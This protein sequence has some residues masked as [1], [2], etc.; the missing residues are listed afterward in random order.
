M[1]RKRMQY[2]IAVLAVSAAAV[3]AKTMSVQVREGVLRS[4]PS[5]LGSPVAALAYGDRV[6]ALEER[7][8]WMRV[9][10]GSTEGW[11]HESALTKKKI[12]LRAGGA[13]E[14]GASGDELA[15]AGKGFN[16][17]VEAQFKSEQ[18]LDYSW[19]DR[20]ERIE[21]TREEMIR[22]LETGGVQP[23]GGAE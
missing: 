20:M 8:G 23:E 9:R 4:R 7:A 3:F 5:F 17:D 18:N 6:D 19:I 15:L 10:S 22:F 21:F 13:V 11:I 14:T 16:S 12:V 2:A 1:Q